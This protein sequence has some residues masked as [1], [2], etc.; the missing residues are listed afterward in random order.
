MGDVYRAVDTRLGRD[1]A[2]KI[3]PEAVAS[4]PQRLAR[5]QREARAL[6]ALE[7]PN[8]V[9]VHSVEQAG[10]LHFLTMQLVRGRNLT[11]LRGERSVPVQAL[12][13][14]ALQLAQPAL[15]V[16]PRPSAV[17]SAA[18]GDTS[19]VAAADRLARAAPGCGRVTLFRRGMAPAARARPGCHRR[20]AAPSGVQATQEAE[21]RNWRAP[22]RQRSELSGHATTGRV[23][24]RLGR[25]VRLPPPCDRR[26]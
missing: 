3:L 24:P 11:E 2:L 6:A 16:S 15:C 18:R 21:Y 13:D 22:G 4:E 25:A 23:T 7:H 8:I 19:A 14:I 5:F 26:R 12:L 1:V 10:G 17:S 9:T 20:Y